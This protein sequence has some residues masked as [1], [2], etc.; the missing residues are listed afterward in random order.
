M[1]IKG[2][3]LI[4]HNA[5]GVNNP[6]DPT[7]PWVLNAN[8]GPPEFMEMAFIC[9]HGGS[10]VIKVRG[11][12]KEALEEFVKVNRLNNHPRLREITITKDQ[13]MNQFKI[14]T[15]H[16]LIVE[17]LSLKLKYLIYSQPST[18][19][20]ML[21]TVAKGDMNNLVRAYLKEVKLLHDPKGFY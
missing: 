21:I 16:I 4:T 15:N 17:R 14:P 12:T 1:E 2:I 9:M 20:E 10:E 6:D 11:K 5:G 18:H 13:L 3:K 8:F 19:D 7:Y